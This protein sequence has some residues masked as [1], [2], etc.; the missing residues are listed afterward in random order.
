MNHSEISFNHLH[1]DVRRVVYSLGWSSLRPIQ[2]L[3]F[4]TYYET[5]D[6]MLVCAATAAGKTESIYLPGLSDIASNPLPSVQVLAILPLKSLINDQHLRLENLAKPLNI[7]VTPWHGDVA[8]EVK[9]RIRKRPEGILLITPESLEATLMRRAGEVPRIFKHLGLVVIDELHAMLESERG[10]HLRSLLSRI[11]SL[12]DHRPRIAGLSATIGDRDV[13][14]AFLN[15]DHP[16]SVRLIEDDD[17][18]RELKVAVI[19]HLEDPASRQPGADGVA[20]DALGQIVNEI[21]TLTRGTTNLIFVNS[22]RDDEEVSARLHRIARDEGWH[23]DPYHSHHGNISKDLRETGEARLKGNKPTT[24]IGTSSI[25]MG[26]DFPGVRL[27]ILIGPPYSVSTL[28]QRWGRSGRTQDQPSI[29]RIYVIDRMPLKGSTLS[30]SLFP[31]LLRTIAL[32]EL[33]LEKTLE[34][35]DGE[36]LHVSTL[37]HQTLSLIRQWG[38]ISAEQTYR[39]LCVAGPFRRIS[40]ELFIDILRSIKARALISQNSEGNLE[41]GHEG[42]IITEEADFYAAF[43]TPVQFTIRHNETTIGELPATQ[44]PLTGQC[45][46]LAGRPWRVGQ[47]QRRNRVVQVVPA[48]ASEPPV[49]LGDP[50]DIHTLVLKRMQQ[51]LRGS[52]V[53]AFLNPDGVNRLAAARKIAVAAR[54]DER[55]VLF[56]SGSISWFPWVGTRTIRTLSLFAAKDNLKCRDEGLSLV[57]PDC[58]LQRFKAHLQFI[59]GS[60]IEPSALAK[61]MSQKF[62]EK[63]DPYLDEAILDEA[64]GNDRLD[65][66]GAHQAAAAALLELEPRV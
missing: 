64:N 13:A 32:V 43:L 20:R 31:K 47:I 51:I 11:F 54:L 48:K 44:L 19:S 65:M 7:R 28:L 58:D 23:D 30:D 60:A 57:Y 21:A 17:L 8:Q 33:A 29:L 56:E 53:P 5:K 66:D 36:R 16:E 37:V 39:T 9:N 6:G 49:F 12:L 38:E 27:A 24:V 62:F 22:R 2:I 45:I 41:L 14:K 42:E 46:T 10:I 15:P 25:E 26:V 61:L 55:E 34:P 50:G 52:P 35:A 59:S 40:Q 18:T 4:K 63:F 1:P 3:A